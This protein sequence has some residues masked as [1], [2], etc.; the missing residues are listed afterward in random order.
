M[1]EYVAAGSMAGAI[2]VSFMH[3]KVLARMSLLMKLT[4]FQQELIS[5]LV[6]EK[7]E[8]EKREKEPSTQAQ[9]EV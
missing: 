2:V 1:I 7:E 4:A 8:A 3:L 9:R 5:Q 6:Q